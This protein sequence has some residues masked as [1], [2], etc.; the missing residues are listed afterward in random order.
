[1]ADKA[2]HISRAK[3]LSIEVQDFQ[4]TSQTDTEVSVRFTQYYR[5][6]SYND[7]GPKVLKFKLE[8]GAWKIFY[9]EMLYANPL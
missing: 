1:M 2:K 6:N 5:S 7:Y 9:E 3:W 4:G 8:G